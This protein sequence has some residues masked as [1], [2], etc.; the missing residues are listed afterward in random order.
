MNIIGKQE[1]TD[2]IS[3]KSYFGTMLLGIL[4]LAG[5]IMLLYWSKSKDVREN[6]QNMCK[7]LA[8]LELTIIYPIFI[9][10]I[11]MILILL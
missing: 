1:T 8:L 2:V 11:V 5:I 3:S 9:L 7:A 4:P 6:K 10:L